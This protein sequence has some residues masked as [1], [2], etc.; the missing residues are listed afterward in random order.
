MQSIEL[1]SNAVSLI[2]RTFFGMQ[3][4]RKEACEKQPEL[5]WSSLES[6]SKTSTAM[7]AFVKHRIGSH[8]IEGTMK[9]DSNEQ[10]QKHSVPNFVKFDAASNPTTFTPDPLKQ[11]FPRAWTVRGMQIDF[12]GQSA[13]QYPAISFNF[14]LGSNVIFSSCDFKKQRFPRNS[15]DAGRQIS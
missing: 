12:K 7:V 8:S 9:T 14:D 2:Y 1:L 11:D 3:S 6:A 10:P 4:D 15:T 13:K 5:I